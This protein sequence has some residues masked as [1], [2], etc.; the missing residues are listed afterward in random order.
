MIICILYICDTSLLAL[1]SHFD[2][3]T[4]LTVAVVTGMFI[5]ELYG[6]S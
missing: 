2:I 1:M 3:D 6:N 4:P 5:I